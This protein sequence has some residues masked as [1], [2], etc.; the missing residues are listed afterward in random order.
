[1]KNRSLIFCSIYPPTARAMNFFR[2]KHR[3]VGFTL[4]EL[5]SVLAIISVLTAVAI[6]AFTSV[7][8]ADSV[9]NAS[10]AVSGVLQRA[11]AYAAA[12]NTYV[13]VGFYEE[14]ANASSPT[15]GAPPYAGMGRL[16]IGT[17]ASADGTQIYADGAT[18][19]PLPTAS[20]VQ[21]DRL[22]RVQNIH[23]TDLGA[24]AGG[25]TP[26]ANRPNGAYAGTTSEQYGINSDSS[27]TTPY[28]FVLGAY[29]FYKTI[30]FSPTGE[31]SID[32]NSELRRIGEIDLRPTHGTNLS[33][34]S[35]NV[36]AIQFTGIGG[37]IQTYRN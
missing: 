10:Y 1:M 28:P 18:A 11:R 14:S 26:L 19:A 5:L 2:S 6:P 25:S 17:V 9:S 22:I 37:G 33:Q 3:T 21:I 7:K 34:N 36:V 8:D 4:V 16:V 31:A 30:R 15:T 24:P 12:H 35:P 13:W 20:L 29:T 32:G 27:E 23:V